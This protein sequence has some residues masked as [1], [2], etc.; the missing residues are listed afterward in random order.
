M[1]QQESARYK[2]NVNTSMKLLNSN[3]TEKRREAA[4]MAGELGAA[5]AI[6]KLLQLMEK[7][8]DPEVRANATY[9]LGMFAAFKA[10]IES[11]DEAAQNAAVGAITQM[12]QTG[13]IGKRATMPVALYRN[14]LYGLSALL[15][16]LILGNV[17]VFFFLGGENPAANTTTTIA[18][19]GNTSPNDLSLLIPLA[20][21]QLQIQTNNAATL[22]QRYE[23]AAAG[24]TPPVETCQ[25]FYNLNSET[26]VLDEA[27][28]AANPTVFTALE[29][30]N[31]ARLSFDAAHLRMEQACYDNLPLTPEDASITLATVDTFLAAVP[32]LGNALIVI[33]T[34]TVVPTQA[35]T[36]TASLPTATPTLAVTATDLPELRTHIA[37][38]YDIIDQ[39]RA[40]RGPS[41]VLNQY[42]Q[43]VQTNN[44]MTG[45]CRAAPPSIPS[46]Y[47]LPDNVVGVSVELTQATERVNQALSFLTV[48]WESFERAC[49]G[50]TGALLS[51]S[52]TGIQVADNVERLLVS[53]QDLL[54]TIR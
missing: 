52:A 7:D 38:L 35:A 41:V 15:V 3:N 45:G 39:S 11:D 6:P 23:I 4:Q 37:A 19:G 1:A 46:P 48:G 24:Q 17:G 30:I 50:G 31:A 53:A 43:E 49:S 9:S 2:K 44:G 36:P 33:P 27:Q 29:Q 54:V 14:L 10:V 18:V 34:P 25:A 13:Q 12:T 16:L 51:E 28:R 26:L 42:W 20:R 21:N 32:A 40:L 22:R 5:Q 47:V 8:P